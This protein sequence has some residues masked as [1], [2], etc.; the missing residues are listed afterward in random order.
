MQFPCETS[1]DLLKKSLAEVN[2]LTTLTENMGSNEW[3][4]CVGELCGRVPQEGK[5]DIWLEGKFSTVFE[6]KMLQ[7][8]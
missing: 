6:L 3:E 2:C 8:Q 7:E 5:A 1:P 4:S